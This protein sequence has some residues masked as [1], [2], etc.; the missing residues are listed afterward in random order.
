MLDRIPPTRPGRFNLPLHGFAQNRIWCA[1]V[2]LAC[3]FTAWMQTLA[4]AD[5]P[6]RR[7][8]PKRLRLRLLSIAGA[9]ATTARTTTM[10]LAQDAPWTDLAIRAMTKLGS[11]ALA[12]TAPSG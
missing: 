8:E 1:I 11:H 10:H 2:A 3:D 6:A 7:W 9:I 12:P 5:H 4:L